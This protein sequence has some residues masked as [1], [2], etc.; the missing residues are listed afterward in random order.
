MATVYK[1]FNASD[2]NDRTIT[3][4]TTEKKAEVNQTLSNF[5]SYFKAKH[6]S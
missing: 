3:N 1:T 5:I 2:V 6:L 4:L